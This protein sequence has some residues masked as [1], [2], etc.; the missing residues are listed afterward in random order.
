MSVIIET[1]THIISKIKS[2]KFA[3]FCPKNILA[4]WG[5]SRVAM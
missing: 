2:V 5:S 4:V 1:S 3:N